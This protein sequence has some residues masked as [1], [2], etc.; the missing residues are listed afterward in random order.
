MTTTEPQSI[1]SLNDKVILFD[2]VCKLCNSWSGF[3]I[4]HDT[5][6]V[7]KLANVQS[8]AGARLLNHFGY[9]TDAFATMLYL[10]G[11][12][13]FEK[14]DAFLRIVGQLGAPWKHLRHLSFI[15]KSIR[16]W[17]YDRIALN[18]YKLFGKYDHCIL[19]QPDHINRF[20]E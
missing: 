4:K 5:K 1:S 11:N 12:S 15:P 2:G 8:E 13:C 20:L 6:R 19:P 10:E 7:F 14:S 18:R 3:I 9:P 17:L 16:D